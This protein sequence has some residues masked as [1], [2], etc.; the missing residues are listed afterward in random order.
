MNQVRR[1]EM[2]KSFSKRAE[3]STRKHVLPFVSHRILCTADLCLSRTSNFSPLL[4]YSEHEHKITTSS[5]NCV[6]SVSGRRRITVS[7]TECKNADTRKYRPEMW[8]VEGS[9]AP[10]FHPICWLH[11]YSQRNLFDTCDLFPRVVR[12]Y[13]TVTCVARSKL[14]TLLIRGAES[15]KLCL[16]LRI[17]SHSLWLKPSIFRESRLSDHIWFTH[18]YNWFLN[19]FLEVR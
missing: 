5:W 8:P 10:G 7:W 14:H 6:S 13:K 17:E 19:Y 16:L 12:S 4:G 1:K 9:S 2:N 15:L 18:Q 3:D 11:Y